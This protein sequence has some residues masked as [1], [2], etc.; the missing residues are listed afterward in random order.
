MQLKERIAMKVR[1]AVA[2]SGLGQS[3]LYEAMQRGE[4]PYLK[5]G[6]SRLIKVADLEE[7]LERHRVSAAAE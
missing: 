7:F 1:D 6:A 2:A 5:V 3:T 4:L